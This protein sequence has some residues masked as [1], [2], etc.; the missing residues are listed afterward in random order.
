M[1]DTKEFEVEDWKPDLS[2]LLMNAKEF[3]NIVSANTNTLEITALF[4]KIEAYT[5]TEAID[6]SDFFLL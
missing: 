4:R 5:R 6:C 1:E 3:Q 2:I